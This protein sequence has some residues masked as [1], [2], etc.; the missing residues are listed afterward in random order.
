MIFSDAEQGISISSDPGTA[1]Q[2]VALT[3]PT[4]TGLGFRTLKWRVLVVDDTSNLGVVLGDRLGT[5]GIETWQAR[6]G[7]DAI[8]Q[9]LEWRPD[10]ILIDM[11]M[12]G[13]NGGESIRGIRQNAGG[14]RQDY[15]HGRRLDRDVRQSALASGADDFICKHFEMTSCLKKFTDCWKEKYGHRRLDRISFRE[16]ECKSGLVLMKLVSNC[17]KKRSNEIL[18]SAFY[19]DDNVPGNNRV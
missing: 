6:N 17:Q 16:G 18:I 19:R 14:S 15:R 4:A 5:A 13:M 3:V 2:A 12:P 11:Y 10:L 7:L 8:L 1:S 9:F